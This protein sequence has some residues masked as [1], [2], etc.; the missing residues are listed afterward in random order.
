MDDDKGMTAAVKR[1]L[2]ASGQY[3]VREQNISERAVAT[4]LEFDPEIILLDWQMPVMDG[5]QVARA[6][7]SEEELRGTPILFITGYGSRAGS[8]GHPVL[9]KPFSTTDLREMVGK[10]IGSSANS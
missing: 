6:I 1:M 3:L 10:L 8:L 7:A 9:Q 4:A 5:I 2:E